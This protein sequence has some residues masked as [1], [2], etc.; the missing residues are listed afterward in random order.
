MTD[1]ILIDQ[2]QVMFMPSFGAAMVVVLPGQLK[3]SGK[4]TVGGKKIGLVG[5]EAQ[6][7]VA[8][9][10]YTA[11]PY[12]IPGTGTLKIDQLAGDQKA[13]HT[14]VGGTKVLLKGSNFTAKFEVQSPAQQPTAGG[15]VPDATPMYSGGQGNFVSTNLKVTGT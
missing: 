3:A 12:V 8:G 5:D 13:Q 2:D 9:C 11:P 6:V 14:T 15:P 7:Q 10:M 1:T 4:A